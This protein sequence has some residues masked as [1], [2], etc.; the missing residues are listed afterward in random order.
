MNTTISLKG[1]KVLYLNR[2][3]L[4][5]NVYVKE[6][7]KEF[8]V[9]VPVM[10]N[11]APE[12]VAGFAENFRYSGNYLLCDVSIDLDTFYGRLLS[13][14]KNSAFI[15][16]GTGTLVKSGEFTVI[17]DYRLTKVIAIDRLKSAFRDG[18][19]LDDALY[20]IRFAANQAK[21][22]VKAELGIA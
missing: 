4:N 22:R 13:S 3:N 14:R 11:E 21:A 8:P 18:N 5:G 2:E 10:M 9:T 16:A 17:K 15:T 19:P 7:I 20:A 12:S 1:R 6:N